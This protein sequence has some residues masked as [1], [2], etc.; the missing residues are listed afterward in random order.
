VKYFS[1][2]ETQTLL[3]HRVRILGNC[4]VDFELLVAP[5]FYLCAQTDKKL[6]IL[7][8]SVIFRVVICLMVVRV[9]VHKTG[10]G[11]DVIEKL[12][13]FVPAVVQ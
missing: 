11:S 13:D 2:S 12:A 4:N 9:R 6:V 1:Y 3:L 10:Q 5:R 7:C 8:N